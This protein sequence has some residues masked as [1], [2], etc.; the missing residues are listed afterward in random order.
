MDNQG[1]C[2]F[3]TG[4]LAKYLYSV[5]IFLSLLGLSGCGGGEKTDND[6]VAHVS[7][8][9]F[10]DRHIE[11]H[12][13]TPQF[14]FKGRGYSYAATVYDKERGFDM[15][16]LILANDDVKL[17]ATSFCATIDNGK[18]SKF[19]DFTWAPSGITY[20]RMFFNCE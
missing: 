7:S 17:A 10:A 16:T 14:L 19:F 8:E 12:E 15:M 3:S 6:V 11:I 4:M 20:H 9:H 5:I 2:H 13:F 1:F 18:P